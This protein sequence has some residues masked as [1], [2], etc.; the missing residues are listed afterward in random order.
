[1]F[2][3]LPPAWPAATDLV[4]RDDGHYRH[5]D[6]MPEIQACLSG[7]VQRANSNLVFLDAFPDAVRK[8]QWL[9]HALE[10]ELNIRLNGSTAIAVI[11]DRA[12]R[13]QQYF[14]DLQSMV[15]YLSDGD[16][17]IAN[18]FPQITGRWSGFRQGVIDMARALIISQ[19]STYHLWRDPNQVT[20]PQ[21][22]PQ[23]A[24]NLLE[25]DGYHFTKTAAVSTQTTN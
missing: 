6:Q 20:D 23:A 3:P 1:M 24:R 25:G 19:D 9:A 16:E 10:R 8:G 5:S 18:D 14:N 13:D 21:E 2:H 11:A 17:V 4:R 22:V 12:Q 7:A 15:K